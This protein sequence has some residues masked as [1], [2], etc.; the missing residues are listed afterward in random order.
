MMDRRAFGVQLIA[1]PV[2]AH[3]RE[4]W[5]LFHSG[6]FLHDLAMDKG[7]PLGERI[8]VLDIL[9]TTTAAFEFMSRMARRF[10]K[11]G[12]V[13]GAGVILS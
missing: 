2:F 11:D 3:H 7:P 13:L 10:F 12:Q 5:V 6:Q 1:D 4:R 8:H 9:D